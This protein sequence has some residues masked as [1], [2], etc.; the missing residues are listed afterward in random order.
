MA[1]MLL[2]SSWQAFTLVQ[3]SSPVT[4]L[5]P[6]TA[7]LS[8]L[9]GEGFSIIIQ[10]TVL[11]LLRASSLFVIV[12]THLICNPLIW[13]HLNLEMWIFR[14]EIVNQLSDCLSIRTLWTY[15]GKTSE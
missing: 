1:L 2:G 9:S 15:Q 4:L 14:T 6:G 5:V 7:S 8:G 3:D 10:E 13:S 11:Q 12:L